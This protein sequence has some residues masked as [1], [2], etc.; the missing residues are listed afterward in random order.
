MSGRP[1]QPFPSV[2]ERQGCLN[3]TD[4][5]QVCPSISG[6]GEIIFR[7]MSDHS[8]MLNFNHTRRAKEY[9]EERRKP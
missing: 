3:V 9:K 2:T 8:V 5:T 6:K 1:V 7:V 4:S